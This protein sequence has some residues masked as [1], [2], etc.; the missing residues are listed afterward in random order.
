[1]SK[2]YLTIDYHTTHQFDRKL[3]IGYCAVH[4]V[5]TVYQ[6]DDYYIVIYQ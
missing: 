3:T 2:R 6:T 5:V 4:D 1:M